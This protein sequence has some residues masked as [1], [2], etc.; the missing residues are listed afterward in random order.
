[1][2]GEDTRFIVWSD[3]NGLPTCPISYW[4]YE[5]GEIDAACLEGMDVVIHL[6]GKSL[7]EDR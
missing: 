5:T 2:N 4:N 3:P 1:L 7:D 6:A